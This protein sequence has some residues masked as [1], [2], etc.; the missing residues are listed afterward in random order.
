[1]STITKLSKDA[2]GKDVKQKLY[3]SMIGSLLYLTTSHP[4]ISFRVRVC[5]RY[6]MNPKE[7]HLC[8]LKELFII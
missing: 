6:Q 2:F 1:M 8:L 4:N 3:K 5:S 7:C